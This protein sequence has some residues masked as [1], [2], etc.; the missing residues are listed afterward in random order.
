MREATGNLFEF[1]GIRCVPTNGV[2][3]KNGDAVMGAG[4]AKAVAG[5]MPH[6]PSLLGE[7]L[8]VWGNI[9]CV[10]EDRWVSFPTKTHWRSPSD[11]VLI[12]DSAFALQS[13]AD[14]L[15]W[16][17]VALPHVGCGLGGLSWENEVRPSLESI[18]DDRF[19]AL[20]PVDHRGRMVGF[21]P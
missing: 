3:K 17:R 18:L 21:N 1:D 11:L 2:R 10:L 8:R 7:H 14:E 16:G 15:G 4:L 6:V 19:V 13:I 20:T 9:P 12:E 5:D